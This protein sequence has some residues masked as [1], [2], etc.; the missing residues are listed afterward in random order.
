MILDPARHP[1]EGRIPPGALRVQASAEDHGPARTAPDRAGEI[2]AV[3]KDTLHQG[4][5]IAR[6]HTPV[7]PPIT[8]PWSR[9]RR[10]LRYRRGVTAMEYAVIAIGMI[11]AVAI[12][13]NAVEVTLAAIFESLLPHLG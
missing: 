12:A 13:A 11:M 1:G 9:A 6:H 5:A 3:P 2:S 8:S 4:C 7:A 10:A